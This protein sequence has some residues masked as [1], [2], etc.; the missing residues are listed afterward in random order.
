MAR[1]KQPVDLNGKISTNFRWREYLY[2]QTAKKLGI[3]N[4]IYAGSPEEQN[5]ID[6]FRYVIQPVRTGIS[7]PLFITS[8]YRCEKLNKAVGGVDDSDHLFA[9]A[10]D[11]VSGRMSPFALAK[12]FRDCYSHHTGGQL[13]FDQLILEH[14]QDAVHASFRGVQESRG[15]I[16]TRYLKDK[17]LV[18]VEGLV[19]EE[20]L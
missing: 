16:L 6:L 14:D 2:S 7:A 5:A 15:I 4:I 13:P 1:K 9:R 11:L 12:A 20:E 3:K 8:G 17:E 10:V 18:Y 19:P